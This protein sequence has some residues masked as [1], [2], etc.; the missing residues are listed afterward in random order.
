MLCL[1]GVKALEYKHSQL[2]F[3]SDNLFD[4]T[5]TV[6]RVANPDNANRPT[7][8]TAEVYVQILITN[9]HHWLRITLHANAYSLMTCCQICCITHGSLVTHPFKVAHSLEVDKV[10][11]AG[12]QGAVPVAIVSVIVT[13][14]ERT[15]LRQTAG[16]QL[17]R[18]VVWRAPGLGFAVRH[19][20]WET[21]LKPQLPFH[22][23]NSLLF[24]HH[25]VC[26]GSREDVQL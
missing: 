11:F 12:V 14:S 19:G 8:L 16:R 6:S 24:H 3:S 7:A 18:V 4:R 13:N 15:G 17:S 21:L 23:L 10:A 1:Q 9:T 2:S 22:F 25:L 5:N 20:Q 26:A